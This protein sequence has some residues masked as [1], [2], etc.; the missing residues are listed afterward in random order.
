MAELTIEAA[1]SREQL[2]EWT[3]VRNA[4]DTRSPS[5]V[6][7]MEF[8]TRAEEGRVNFLLAVSHLRAR[9]ESAAAAGFGS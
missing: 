3:R 8:F 7:E 2:V 9:F 6:E 5:T 4:V 1:G